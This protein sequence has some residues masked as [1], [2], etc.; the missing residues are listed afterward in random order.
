MS[1]NLNF[2]HVYCFATLKVIISVSARLP[3][4][5]SGVKVPFLFGKSQVA[6]KRVDLERM[7]CILFKPTRYDDH[8]GGLSLLDVC[9]L[10]NGALLNRFGFVS[11]ENDS[12][13]VHAWLG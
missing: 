2:L 6:R 10:K 8:D 4:S 5:R 12:I 1:I 11:R 13:R 9:S 3:I 7:Y